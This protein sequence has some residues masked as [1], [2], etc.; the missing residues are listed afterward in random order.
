MLAGGKGVLVAGMATLVAK[1]TVVV[2][3]VEE[4]TAS[5]V[6]GGRVTPAVVGVVVAHSQAEE[7]HT[8]IRPEVAEIA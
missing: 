4:G 2:R 6:A 1:H 8:Q 5:P 7:P 3:L